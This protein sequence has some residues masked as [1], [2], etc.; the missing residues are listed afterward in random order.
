MNN[1]FERELSVA[2]TAV[3]EAAVLCRNVRGSMTPD[4]MDKNDKSPVTVADFGSQALVCARLAEAFPD[5]PVMAEEDSTEL[6][7]NE[8][9]AIRDRVAQE[10]AAVRS[11]TSPETALSWIDH[12]NLDKYAEKFWVLDPIDGTKGYLRGEQYAIALALI[13]NGEV[14]VAALGCPNLER[15]GAV[16]APIGALFAGVRGHGATIQPLQDGEPRVIKV[17]ERSDPRTA[18]FCESVESAHSAHGDAA[19]AAARL[20]ITEAP[21]RLDSQAKY[22][23][24][25]SGGAEIYLRLPTKPG[26]KEKIW[27]HAAGFLIIEEAGGKVTDLEG[28]ALEFQH[29]QNLEANRG[30]VATNGRF[31]DQVLEALKN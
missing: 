3:R 20:G 19:V 4:S 14:Q 28:K 5:V 2:L 17:S 9:N 30:I 21:V 13:V 1:P 24:V 22:A 29:G 27:D 15:D 16:G 11:G 8:N 18:R 26:R 7:K 6:R 31:H 12:G 23:V 10:V 25:G